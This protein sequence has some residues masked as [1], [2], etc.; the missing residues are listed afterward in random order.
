MSVDITIINLSFCPQFSFLLSHDIKKNNDGMFLSI[1]VSIRFFPPQFC[2]VDIEIVQVFSFVV[3]LAVS[4]VSFIS[5]P[6]R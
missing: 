3:S 5:N 4:K 6:M 1:I 2:Q